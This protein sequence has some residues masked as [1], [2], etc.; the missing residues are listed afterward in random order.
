MSVSV[1]EK[2][3][4]PDRS[5]WGDDTARA[6]MEQL[7]RRR[8]AGEG[9]HGDGHLSG[10]E[11]VAPELILVVGMRRELWRLERAERPVPKSLYRLVET[12]SA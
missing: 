10:L 3:A 11:K 5:Q 8:Q 6:T 4:P 1:S 2:L 7:L 12:S 9:W